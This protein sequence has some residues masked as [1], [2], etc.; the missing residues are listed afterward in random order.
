M[1]ALSPL[2]RRGTSPFVG[3]GLREAIRKLD[4]ALSIGDE[5]AR[6]ATVRLAMGDIQACIDFIR[7]SDR[8]ADRE[9]LPGFH[10]SLAALGVAGVGSAPTDDRGRVDRDSPAMAG[11]T[12]LPR[13]VVPAPTVP[14]PPPVHVGPP[15]VP[16]KVV[17]AVRGLTDAHAEWRRDILEELLEDLTSF[18]SQRARLVRSADAPAS[19]L[20]R[21]DDRIRASADGLALAGRFFW[22][23]VE[24]ALEEPSPALFQACALPLAIA[25]DERAHGL[26]EAL[27]DADPVARAGVV[28][29]LQHHCSEALRARFAER[30]AREPEAALLLAPLPSWHPPPGALWRWLEQPEVSARRTFWQLLAFDGRRT[31]PRFDAVPTQQDFARG[32]ADADRE[33]RASCLLT[34][35]WRRERWLLGHCRQVVAASGPGLPEAAWAL[36][37]I[38]EPG[39]VRA[40]IDARA[41]LA[42]VVWTEILVASGRPD[43][44]PVLLSLMSGSAEVPAALAGRAFRRLTGLDVGTTRRVSIPSP[45]TAG[46]PDPDFD[47]EIE[48]GDG[49]SAAAA[50]TRAAAGLQSAV[51]LRRGRDIAALSFEA[52]PSD[53]DLQAR[54]DAAIRAAWNARGP[55]TPFELL[56]LTGPDPWI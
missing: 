9:Q 14:A 4:Q 44:I 46:Q 41:A 3:Q 1:R 36:C 6:A 18:W 8:P 15:E 17:P 38:G 16:E 56:R 7:T 45:E 12:P 25:D 42:D 40:V 22:P 53:L 21:L 48:L 24:A 28:E 35:I 50:W 30:A 51:R 37:A 43:V 31:S 32:L 49:E 11:A 55:S 19:A 13:M 5:A 2:R 20:F 23:L 29:A 27:F 52:W 34:A 33:V 26:I 54:H 47:E 10:A 39:D